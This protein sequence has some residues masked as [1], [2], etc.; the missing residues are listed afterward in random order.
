MDLHLINQRLR[1]LYGCDLLGQPVY[2]V[3]WSEDQIE[4][5]FADFT[6]FVPNTNILLR[7]VTE[8]REVKKYSYLEPQYVLEKLFRNQH[9]KEILDNATLAPQS[10]T[11]EP[12]WAFDY[13]GKLPKQPVWRAIELIIMS[14]NNPEKLTPS[15]MNDAEMKQALD[16][17][18][19]MVD[20]MN[21]HIKSDA[22]HS[23]VQDGDT[24]MLGRGTNSV[25]E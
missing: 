16:D 15:E 2:R 5:R 11:Y 1:D 24:I 6:D 8:M 12:L 20:L 22:L 3:V 18:K 19:L 14:V 21:K 7:K 10:C 9:N 4:K 25:T 13:D 17:E 23:S